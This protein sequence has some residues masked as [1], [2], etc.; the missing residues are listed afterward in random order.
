M[1]RRFLIRCADTS[2]NT[3]THTHWGGA[4]L[5]GCSIGGCECLVYLNDSI[6]K[7]VPVEHRFYDE[8]VFQDDVRA[9]EQPYASPQLYDLVRALAGGPATS[10]DALAGEISVK[11]V[12]LLL[13]PQLSS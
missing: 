9:A 4:A 3:H 5:G 8:Y 2:R 10:V 13:R 7:D 12:C 6:L 1:M 11:H